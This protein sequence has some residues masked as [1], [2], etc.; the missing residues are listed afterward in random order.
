MLIIVQVEK[1]LYLSGETVDLYFQPDKI[2][3]QPKNYIILNLAW[4]TIPIVYPISTEF[5]L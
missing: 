1:Q 3:Y 5:V 4:S 2:R